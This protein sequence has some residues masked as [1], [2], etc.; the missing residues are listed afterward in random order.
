[1]QVQELNRRLS[2]FIH[3]YK[4]RSPLLE[5]LLSLMLWLDFVQQPL[6]VIRIALEKPH[7]LP[8]HLISIALPQRPR[9]TVL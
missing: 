4:C 3:I 7:I 8:I 9:A 1:M 5:C 2:I 6:V